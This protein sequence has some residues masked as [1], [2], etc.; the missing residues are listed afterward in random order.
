MLNPA[1]TITITLAPME[2]I[3]LEDAYYELQYHLHQI[4]LVEEG[5]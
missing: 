4:G 3:D 5:A 1:E 2:G